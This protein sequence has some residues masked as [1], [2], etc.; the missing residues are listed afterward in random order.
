M[1]AHSKHQSTA[2]NYISCFYHSTDQ[3]GRKS[4]LQHLPAIAIS[5]HDDGW[6]RVKRLAWYRQ[7]EAAVGLVSSVVLAFLVFIVPAVG[8]SAG[9][10]VALF[11]FADH[12]SLFA[13]PLLCR[14]FVWL[15]RRAL[16]H[17]QLSPLQPCAC[18]AANTAL[19]LCHLYSVS[20]TRRPLSPAMSSTS[21]FLRGVDLSMALLCLVNLA[22]IT[23]SLASHSL[24][25][26]LPPSATSAYLACILYCLFQHVTLLAILIIRSLP[27]LCRAAGNDPLAATCCA[28]QLAVQ[29]FLLLPRTLIVLTLLSTVLRSRVLLLGDA[30]H[31]VLYLSS[32]LLLFMYSCAILVMDCQSVQQWTA[33]AASQRPRPARSTDEVRV[34]GMSMFGGPLWTTMQNSASAQSQRGLSELEIERV[35]TLTTFMPAAVDKRAGDSSEE[36]KAVEMPQATTSVVVQPVQ[37]QQSLSATAE[38]DTQAAIIDPPH[39]NN[40]PPPPPSSQPPSQPAPQTV[41]YTALQHYR[42]CASHLSLPFVHAASLPVFVQCS[43]CLETLRAGESVLVLPCLVRLLSRSVLFTS[44]CNVLLRCRPLT[45]LV[46]LHL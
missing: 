17:S 32:A 13:I 35:T 38:E 39:F 11:H 20:Q 46:G 18:S 28:I 25:P 22:L 5:W 33:G 10:A 14:S 26:H 36:Q 31:A 8:V 42:L 12:C 37:D 15:S 41:S 21:Q 9:S 1:K 44:C 19:V 3:T 40:P 7:M 30:A 16:Q 4:K 45:V 2:A 29:L 43:V 24:P 23:D 34:L 6:K 27:H